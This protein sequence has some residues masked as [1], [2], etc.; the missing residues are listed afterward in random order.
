MTSARGA[1][2]VR[3]AMSL[4][5]YIADHDGGYDWIVPVPSPGLDTAHQLPFDDF[6][7]DVDIVVMGRH[8]YEQGQS[9]DYVALGKRVIVA[10]SDA[11]G[12]RDTC[13]G[14]EFSDDVVGTVTAAREHG[15]HCFVF[16]GGLLVHSFVAADA[17]DVL[18]VSIVPVLLGG[19][20]SLFPGE[21]PTINL[22]LTD[23]AIA[24]GKA[25]LVYQHR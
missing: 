4:D 12:R 23:Y 3:L 16:G 6:L 17:V 24:D 19:G 5:G 2:S 8:C 7:Q 14:I 10:T 25:R 9:E 18:T 1:I 21:H 20:R 11:A 15:Q 22:R 13:A